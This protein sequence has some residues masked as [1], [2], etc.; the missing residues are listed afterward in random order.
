MRTLVIG[1]IGTAFGVLI[2]MVGRHGPE[3]LQF[4][5]ALFYP[6]PVIIQY[7]EDWFIPG[8]LNVYLAA[9][10]VVVIQVIYYLLISTTIL[11]WMIKPKANVRQG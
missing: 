11:R 8:N 4:T 6:A 3:W 9:A 7:C 2:M 5:A 10:M 1:T